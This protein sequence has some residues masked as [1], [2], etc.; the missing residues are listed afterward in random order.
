MAPE[1]TEEKGSIFGDSIDINTF[2]QI[3]E[4]DDPDDNEFSHSIVFG[5]FTQA[6]ETFIKMDTAIEEKDLDQ[7][8]ELGHFLKG[9]SATLGM[10]KVR[11]GCEKIQ[12]FGKNENVDGSDEPD[13]DLCL[14]RIIEALESVKEDYKDV[15]A[16]L[17]KYYG[18]KG[19]APDEGDE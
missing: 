1:E 3:L 6:E 12:R 2:D 18:A 10:V 16:K 13:S 9:S 15:E 7:L 14:Q 19:G 17:K 4:M 11:D 5:F 8:S